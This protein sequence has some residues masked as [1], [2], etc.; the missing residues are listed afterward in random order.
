MG[1]QIILFAEFSESNSYRDQEC[2]CDIGFHDNAAKKFEREQE[3]IEREQHAIREAE[4]RH[5][6]EKF[7]KYLNTTYTISFILNDSQFLTNYIYITLLNI[8]L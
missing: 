5:A 7:Q 8:H 1:V 3:C 4:K 2:Y 6:K